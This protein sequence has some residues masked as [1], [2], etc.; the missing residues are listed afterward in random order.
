MAYFVKEA[1]AGLVK[2][3]LIFND[4]SIVVMSKLDVKGQMARTVS[5]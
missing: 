4:G 1:D 2:P 5:N 3:P